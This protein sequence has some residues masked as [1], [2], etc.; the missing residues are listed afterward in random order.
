MGRNAAIL[1]TINRIPFRCLVCQSEQ[2]FDREVKLNTTGAEFMN[3]GWSNQSATGLV[4]ARCGYVHLF[5]ND[6]IE[7]WKPGGGYPQG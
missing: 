6:A 5:L 3:L 2:F 4:C 7:F 1:V